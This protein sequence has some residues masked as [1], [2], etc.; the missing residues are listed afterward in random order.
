MNDNNMP[1]HGAGI[2]CHNACE[3]GEGPTYD[4]DTGTL[5]WFDIVGRKLLERD[6]P[7]GPTRVHDLPFMASALAVVD[8]ERQ[9]IAAEDGLYLR[10]RTS[11]A[12]TLHRPLEADN[13][14]TRSN[15]ARVHPS[16]A[17]WIGTMA[18][19]E[20]RDAG[21]IY[22][23]RNGEIRQLYPGIS[24]P[25]SICFSPDGAIAYYTDTPRAIVYRVACDPATGLPTGDPEPF[26]DRRGKDGWPDG[27]VCD[28]EG[29]IWNARWGAGALDKWS[30]GGQLI[31]TIAIPAGQSSCPAFA[32]PDASQIVVT[33][34]WKGKDAAA[35]ER[36][37]HAGKTFVVDRKVRGR[38]ESRVAL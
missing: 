21:A 6:F 27:S 37:P 5:Y 23:Y 33:S 2:L 34:A 28:A 3:L 22:W 12:L 15:D 17:F 9:L 18:K 1:G 4:P 36:D 31:E 35:R 8:D 32:G 20:G 11:G 13:P 38:F 30:P 14:N 25:N 29:N 26:I 16:G 19:D 10:E 7:D 24:I